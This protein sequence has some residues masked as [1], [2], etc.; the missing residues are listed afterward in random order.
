[1]DREQPNNCDHCMTSFAKRQEII[2]DD[3][4]WFCEICITCPN[5]WYIG[6]QCHYKNITLEEADYEKVKHREVDYDEYLIRDFIVEY[7]KNII[8]NEVDY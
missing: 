8:D 6:C 1:M 2:F 5:R 7:E 3:H 4:M